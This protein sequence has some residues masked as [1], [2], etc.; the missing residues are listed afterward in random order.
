M[1]KRSIPVAM[2]L[3]L[4][5]TL[6]P[7]TAQAQ[8]QVPGPHPAYLH[9]LSELR[10]ARAYLDGIEWPPIRGDRDRAI[11]QIDAAIGDIKNAAIDDGKNLNDHPPVE[12]NME[13][14]GRFRAALDLLDK[15]HNDV[16][17]AEDVRKSRG[18][19]DRALRDI[20]SAHAAV[21][22]A[23]KTVRWDEWHR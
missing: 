18:L 3:A 5:L 6:A 13:P 20:D 8:E 21:D 7:R 2:A 4:C 14:N 15:A 22:H 17:Q 9:A 1:L 19:R 12:M 23:V 11:H 16:A 10:A